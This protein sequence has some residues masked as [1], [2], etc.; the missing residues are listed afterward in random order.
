MLR[1]G[2]MNGLNRL[3]ARGFSEKDG[4]ERLPRSFLCLRSGGS[5]DYGTIIGLLLYNFLR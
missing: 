3:M 2:G 5:G 4:K 1:P